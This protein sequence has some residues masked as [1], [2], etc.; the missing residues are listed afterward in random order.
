MTKMSKRMR[1]IMTVF[2]WIELLLSVLI[3]GGILLLRKYPD[4]VT[5][6]YENKEIISSSLHK[7]ISSAAL[8]LGF[9]IVV[10]WCII[11]TA[12]CIFR[13]IK[14]DEDTSKLYSFTWIVTALC[15]VILFFGWFISEDSLLGDYDPKCFEFSDGEHTV[16]IEEESWLLG[17]WGNIYQVNDD[18][19]AQRLSRFSTDDGFR[20]E[21]SYDINWHDDSAD[22]T[23]DNGN[24]GRETVTVKFED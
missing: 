16:V 20:N 19:S 3:V 12:I 21:G 9:W 14:T 13:R 5:Y 11:I 10:V 7:N 2:P 15:T 17:G 24:G 8:T 22:I 23:Y 1:R 6:T 4:T 18:G